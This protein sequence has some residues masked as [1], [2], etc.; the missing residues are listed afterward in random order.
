MTMS[1]AIMAILVIRQDRVRHIA[2][3]VTA[4]TVSD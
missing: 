3:N 4:E 1:A 2:V